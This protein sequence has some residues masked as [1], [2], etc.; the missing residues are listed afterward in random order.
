MQT[1]VELVAKKRDGGRLSE[2][3]I[4]RIIRALSDGELADYQMAALL[5]AIFFRGMDDA[6]TVALTRAM[7]HSG[8]VLDLSS[9]PG[10]K[11]DKHS[12]GGVGDKVSICLAPLVAACGVPVPMV[13]G[14]GLGHTGGTLDKLEA[15]PGFDVALDVDAFARIVREVGTCMIGQTAR[16][17]PADKRIYALRDVTATVESIPLIVASILSKKLAEGIDA[18]VLDVKVGRGAFMKTLGDARALATALV[19]VGT[20][21]GKRVSALLTDMS[22]PLGRAVGNA[23]ETRE[24]IEVL[25]GR[26]P[27]DLVACTLALGEEMLIAGGAAASAAEARPKLEAAIA[28]GAAAEVLARMIAAQ[29]GDPAVVQD[30][31][32][33]PSAPVVVE[34]AAQ[35]EGYVAAV[36]PLEIGLSA[37]AL[38]AGRTRA[39]QRVDPAVGIE[40]AAVRGD[41]VDRGAPLARIHA[42]RADDARAAADRVRAAFRIGPAPAEAPALVLERIEA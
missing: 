11:V 37:V 3:E 32:R 6:E 12:T 4:A 34:V 18:L 42:R 8:D 5:M 39:D 20:A 14:R 25:H 38:G 40:L 28:S 21:A 16:I 19:R 2:D 22:A 29:K 41:R 9:V 15:I 26:G 30:A 31:G 33:L 36:D 17:A 13:S 27:G 1:L 10:R 7:L 23:I 24:A 35:D